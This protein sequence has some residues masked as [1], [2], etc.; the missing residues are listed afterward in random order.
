MSKNAQRPGLRQRIPKWL[1]GT[2]VSLYHLD[3]RQWLKN[4][5]NDP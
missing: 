5:D 2:L 4:V 3:N 1:S